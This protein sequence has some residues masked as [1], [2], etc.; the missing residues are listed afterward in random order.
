M[1][2]E[3]PVYTFHL[4]FSLFQ[5]SFFVASMFRAGN[6]KKLTLETRDYQETKQVRNGKSNFHYDELFEI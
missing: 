5:L 4:F 3:R 2:V 6:G 1:G